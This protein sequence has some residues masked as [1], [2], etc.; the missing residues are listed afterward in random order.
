MDIRSFFSPTGKTT[1]QGASKVEIK[2]WKDPTAKSSSK[3]NVG[4]SRSKSKGL[5]SSEDDEITRKQ[6][7]KKTQK[8]KKGGNIID[9]DSDEDPLP[10]NIRKAT[11]AKKGESAK[12]KKSRRPISLDSDE[13]EVVPKKLKPSA[14]Q[15]ET[16]ATKE[17]QQVKDR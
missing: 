8:K 3:Q 2:R 17:V 15:T 10:P 6:K 5:S 13:E 1:K 7:L 12:A 16:K 4:K 14:K 9:S 11:S